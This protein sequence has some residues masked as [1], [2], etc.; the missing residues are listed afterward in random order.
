MLGTQG[1]RA[2]ATSLGIDVGVLE[3]AFRRCFEEFERR[4]PADVA[5]PDSRLFPFS[6]GGPVRDGRFGLVCEEAGTLLVR[7]CGAVF[8]SHGE[9]AVIPDLPSFTGAALGVET[10]GER[11]RWRTRY[12][13]Y[14]VEDSSSFFPVPP[15][16]VRYGN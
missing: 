13:V 7:V 11:S 6:V 10:K 12:G 5:H 16:G 4:E 9:R 15:W 3:R 1:S 14:G 2:S 8:S